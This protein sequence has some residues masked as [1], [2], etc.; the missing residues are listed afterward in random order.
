MLFLIAVLPVV[1]GII[2]LF[3]NGP[4]FLISSFIQRFN[5]PSFARFFREYTL[6]H[7][8]REVLPWYWGIYDWLGVT[9]PRIIHRAINIIIALSGLGFLKAGYGCISRKRTHDKKLVP[10]VVFLLFTNLVYF[11]GISIFDW[12]NWYGSSYVLGVQGRYFFPLLYSHM[13]LLFMGWQNL[14]PQRYRP[15]G[16]KILGVLMI[17]LNVYA[18]YTV[19]HTYYDL[20]NVSIFINQA[21]QYKPW[22]VKNTGLVAVISLFIISLTAFLLDYVRY[23][24][25]IIAKN[26]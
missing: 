4:L 5:L 2:Y 11:M 14:F 15:A 10:P 19:A 6:V 24:G 18:L 12:S 13:L 23:P 7:T 20:S 16:M 25:K 21:S 9:Y 8:Y 22:F 26:K 3:R 17:G 1:A